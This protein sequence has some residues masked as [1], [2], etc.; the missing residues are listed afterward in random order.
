LQGRH[1]DQVDLIELG[2]V[3][4][5]EIGATNDEVGGLL[6]VD[7]GETDTAPLEGELFDEARSD[8]V[9]ATCDEHGAIDE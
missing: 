7:V 6:G 2:L 3:L 8:T 4:D 1:V 9:G 5:L